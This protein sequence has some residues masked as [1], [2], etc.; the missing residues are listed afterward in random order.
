ML[1]CMGDT[2]PAFLVRNR[3]VT[4]RYELPAVCCV[5]VLDIGLK[6]LRC[7]ASNG[8]ISRHR[9]PCVAG[10]LPAML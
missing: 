4:E 2:S 3:Q 10:A 8:E 5:A 1:L 6:I 9:H 7:D